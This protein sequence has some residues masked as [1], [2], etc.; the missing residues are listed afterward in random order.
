MI[1]KSRSHKDLI[2]E[3]L[4]ISSKNLNIDNIQDKYQLKYNDLSPFIEKIPRKNNILQK[5]FYQTVNRFNF[6]IP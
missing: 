4:N 6:E 5:K 3:S 1:T 2:D